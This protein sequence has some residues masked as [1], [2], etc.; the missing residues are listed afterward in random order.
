MTFLR[1]LLTLTAG[2][3]SALVAYAIVFTHGDPRPERGDPEL[4]FRLLPLE[5]LIGVIVAF[6][7]YR[8]VGRRHGL[9]PRTDVAERMVLRLAHRRGGR[10]TVSDLVQDS[11]LT[12]PQAR[13][14]LTRMLDAG[15]VRAE[16][17]TPDTYRLA[18]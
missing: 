15:R 10:F 9:A 5:L 16:G 4:A 8:A 6:L 17:G 13:E 11:P 3:G 18:P 7:V 1:A 2:I 12:E 14:T